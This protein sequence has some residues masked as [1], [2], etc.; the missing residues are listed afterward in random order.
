MFMSVGEQLNPK[1]SGEP[2]DLNFGRAARA[3]AE[4]YLLAQTDPTKTPDDIEQIEN[5]YAF[6]RSGSCD[7]EELEASM[8]SD[9]VAA[10]FDEVVA[11]ETAGRLS[12]PEFIA[13]IWTAGFVKE[14]LPAYGLRKGKGKTKAY[15]DEPTF[16][17]KII[18]MS[19]R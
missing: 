2:T 8:M 18:R 13:K 10:G 3:L 14:D 6:A 5:C 7:S 16:L 1:A 9:L 11:R 12:A 19:Q 15:I 4:F 17:R